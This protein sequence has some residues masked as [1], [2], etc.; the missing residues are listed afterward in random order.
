M[1]LLWGF[2][3]ITCTR[4]LVPGLARRRKG[5]AIRSCYFQGAEGEPEEGVGH[6]HLARKSFWGADIFEIDLGRWVI[7]CK[8]EYRL[9]PGGSEAPAF[10]GD[11]LE[12]L[13]DSPVA[14][15]APAALSGYH[16]VHVHHPAQV[17]F[18]TILKVRITFCGSWTFWRANTP[19]K[20]LSLFLASSLLIEKCGWNGDSSWTNS[21]PAFQPSWWE[22]PSEPLLPASLTFPSF[23]ETQNVGSWRGAHPHLT[24][25]P[26]HLPLQ[27]PE[28]L[29]SRVH[30]F[31]PK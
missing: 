18:K 9:D 30:I 11:V 12:G 1:G 16:V 5:V 22:F 25:A 28:V 27:D 13:G 17:R 7:P 15:K 8:E 21:A 20:W 29:C 2:S 31:S 26:S 10:P 3:K 4:P 19:H 6:S 24:L 23:A 14:L